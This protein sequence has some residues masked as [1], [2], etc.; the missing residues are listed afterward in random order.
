MARLKVASGEQ[1]DLGVNNS[2]Q[3]A[4]IPEGTYLAKI[5]SCKVETYPTRDGSQTYMKLQPVVEIFND[6]GTV[7]KGPGSSVTVGV[8]DE[9]GSIYQPDPKKKA[10]GISGVWVETK[11]FLSSIGWTDLEDFDS[12]LVCGQLVIVSVYHRSYEYQGQ[13]RQDNAVGY[14]REGSNRPG[15]GYFPVTLSKLYSILDFDEETPVDEQPQVFRDMWQHE[16]GMWFENEEAAEAYDALADR[17][18]EDAED[19]DVI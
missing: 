6:N 12:D 8:V 2:L 5:T 3:Y 4:L 16:N 13:Q 15:A 9:D 17:V 18:D 7:I 14:Q 1:T 11:F 10:D 19:E